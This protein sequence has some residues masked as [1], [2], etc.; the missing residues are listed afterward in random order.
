MSVNNL[1]EFI[2]KHGT[3]ELSG[4]TIKVMVRDI[5]ETW[6]RTRYL[7]TPVAGSGEIFVENIRISE[8]FR[9]PEVLP[10]TQSLRGVSFRGL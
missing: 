6:G 9:S 4:L 2:G 5:K 8:V 1:K 3:I 7:V 10:N